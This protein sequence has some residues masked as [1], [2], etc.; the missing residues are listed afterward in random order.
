MKRLALRF[1]HPA[2]AEFD[3]VAEPRNVSAVLKALPGTVSIAAGAVHA[4]SKRVRT[5]GFGERWESLNSQKPRSTSSSK[6]RA[7][8]V[9]VRARESRPRP[10]VPLAAGEAA[11][12]GHLLTLRHAEPTLNRLAL[13]F[14]DPAAADFDAV[15]RPRKVSAALKALP[16]AVAVDGGSVRAGQSRHD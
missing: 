13:R 5:T 10:V 9:G 11:T 16:G 8:L 12:G 7:R 15:V 4:D 1:D 14:D 3:A 2:A 6:A